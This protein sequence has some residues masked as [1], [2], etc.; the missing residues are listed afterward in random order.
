MKDCIASHSKRNIYL[1]RALLSA[2]N[3][4][5]QGAQLFL[6]DIYGHTKTATEE[7]IIQTVIPDNIRN[8]LANIYGNI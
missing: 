6:L 3:R 4:P 8:K 5:S 7:E 2:M 1:S